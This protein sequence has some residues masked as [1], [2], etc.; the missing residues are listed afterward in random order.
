METLHLRDMVFENLT[1]STTLRCRELKCHR[2]SIGDHCR[3]A[4]VVP[5]VVDTV[6]A[7]LSN[8]VDSD[9]FLDVLP[10]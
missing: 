6:S 10:L 1:E 5:K 4:Q 7:S 3:M 8:S 2:S 9:G